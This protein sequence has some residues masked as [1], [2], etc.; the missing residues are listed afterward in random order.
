M[1]YVGETDDGDDAIGE[2]A[3]ADIQRFDNQ[4]QSAS[5]AAPLTRFERAI[6]KSYIMV[7]A[8][9]VGS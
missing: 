6:L 2:A 4:L 8:Q 1:E 9:E 7:R 3:D 5:G